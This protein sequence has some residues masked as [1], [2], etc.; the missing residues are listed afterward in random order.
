MVSRIEVQLAHELD[1]SWIIALY[2]AIHGG[3]PP[4][5]EQNVRI[6]EGTIQTVAELAGQIRETGALRNAPP[7]TLAMLQARMKSFGIEVVQGGKVEAESFGDPEGAP[8]QPLPWCFVF[9]GQRICVARPPV[10]HL[11]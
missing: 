11:P 10:T 1:A 5:N 6:N 3:D 9:R 4:P 7:L 8:R 2:L